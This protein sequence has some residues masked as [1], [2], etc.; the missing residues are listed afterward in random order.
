MARQITLQHIEKLTPDTYLLRYDCPDDFT[1]TPGQ[2]TDLAFDLPGIADEKRPFTFS[3]LPGDPRL[4]FVI[5]SYPED[6]PDH[7]G[8]TARL[9]DLRPG[10]TAQMGAPW[11]AIADHGPGTFIAGGA[12]ITPFIP[13]LRAHAQSGRMKCRLIFA[14]TAADD[15]ILRAEWDAMD[16][17]ETVYVTDAKDDDKR[18]GPVDVQLLRA[19]VPDFSGTF[20]LCGPPPMVKAVTEAL[21]ECGVG[22]DQIVTENKPSQEERAAY[23]KAA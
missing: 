19:S 17:L 7:D 18:T 5:K 12:G 6:H 3:S 1:W 10:D 22:G 13:I 9:P 16:G 15:I 21:T 4:D 20:Y 14:N 23:F 11:G 8:V 2:A